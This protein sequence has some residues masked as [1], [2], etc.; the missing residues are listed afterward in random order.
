MGFKISSDDIKNARKVIKRHFLVEK[1]GERIF[2]DL[3]FCLCS[4]QT[5][6][7]SNRIV[8]ARLI[9]R[10]FYHKSIPFEELTEVC[11]EVRFKKNKA[12][13]LYEAREIFTDIRTKM[14]DPTL[15]SQDKREWLVKNIRGFGMKTSSH[16]LRNLGHMDLAIIDTHILKYLNEK[17]PSSK[18][19]YLRIEELFRR[20]SR[21]KNLSP[22][23]LDTIIWK[24]YSKTSWEDFIC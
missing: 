13:A 15:S 12:R 5:T 22:A 11:T 20:D 17:P 19:E 9:D 3:C 1:N 24:I 18:K 4:P 14:F 23:E 8:N 2:Y 10:D 21:E 6:F 16:F 7:K